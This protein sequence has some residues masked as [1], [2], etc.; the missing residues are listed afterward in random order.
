MIRLLDIL[1]R[2][3]LSTDGVDEGFLS[4]IERFLIFLCC[5]SLESSLVCETPFFT[6]SLAEEEDV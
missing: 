6:E 1:F 5:C 4:F 3:K 2:G